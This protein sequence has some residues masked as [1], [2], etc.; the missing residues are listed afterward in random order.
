MSVDLG[1]AAPAGSCTAQNSIILIKKKQNKTNIAPEPFLSL[2]VFSDSEPTSMAMQTFT[3]D[4]QHELLRADGV[5]NPNQTDS[6]S[7]SRKKICT[8]CVSLSHGESPDRTPP[9]FR[10]HVTHPAKVKVMYSFHVQEEGQYPVP[11]WAP[12]SIS[13]RSLVFKGP[14]CSGD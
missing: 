12:I 3:S 13:D 8:T 9:W 2:T 5:Q 1:S 10:R 6:K 11:T 7:V 4:P 14:W